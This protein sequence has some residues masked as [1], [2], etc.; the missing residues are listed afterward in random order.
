MTKSSSKAKL[1]L[2][3]TQLNTLDELEETSHSNSNSTNASKLS[4]A[5]TIT[6]ESKKKYSGDKRNSFSKISPTNLNTARSNSSLSTASRLKNRPPKRPLSRKKSDIQSRSESVMSMA[7]TADDVE[8]GVDYDIIVP[9]QSGD[10]TKI[11]YVNGYE[12]YLIT[13]VYS[14]VSHLTSFLYN[15]SDS[16]IKSFLSKPDENECLPLFYAIKASCLTTVKYLINL[17][18]SLCQTTSAGDPAPHLACLLGVSV[19]VIAYLIDFDAKKFLT[20]YDQEGWS[21]LHC[22]CN[23]GHLEIVKYLIEVYFINPNLKDKNSHTG[24]QLA[25][26]NNHLNIV[27][28]FLT[29]DAVSSVKIANVLKSL[30]S[31]KDTSISSNFS[32]NMS[33]MAMRPIENNLLDTNS[34][35]SNSA[36]GSICL[37]ISEKPMMSVKSSNENDQIN[38]SK[39]GTLDRNKN[40]LEPIVLYSNLK[41]NASEQVRVYGKKLIDLNNKNNLGQNGKVLSTFIKVC[42]VAKETNTPHY[43][44]PNRTRPYPYYTIRWSR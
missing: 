32:M 8:V 41:K 29:F 14:N 35:R 44:N 2:N 36:F 19:E 27:K 12:K 40:F 22:A 16:E 7:D 31:N 21:I 17:G 18:A 37:R 43:P 34:R 11:N 13:R 23:Q 24:L 38:Q 6:V 33:S 25:V 15:K 26:V 30:G 42:R 20:L 3:A 9:P 10:L 4:N 5:H 1:N 28:Y 39:Y